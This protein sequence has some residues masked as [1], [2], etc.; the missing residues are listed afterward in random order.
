MLEKIKS[1]VCSYVKKWSGVFIA[2]L[3]LSV[4][5]YSLL[6]INQLVNQLDGLWHGSESVA[7]G[8][9]LSIGRWLWP[10]LDKARFHMSPDPVTSLIALV[11]F[12]TALIAVLEIF[13]VKPG[14]GAVAISMIFL[15]S[16]SVCN[17]LSFRYMSLTFTFAFFFAVVAAIILIKGKRPIITMIC[18]ALFVVF[19]NALYQA[20][21]G[22]ICLLIL[23]YIA[24]SIKKNT[25]D[26]RQLLQFT[27]RSLISGVAGV[28]VYYLMWMEKLARNNV[29]VS[30]YNGASEYGLSGVITNFPLR[31]AT[32]YHA[33][34]EYFGNR[35]FRINT[36]PAFKWMYFV[37]V[38]LI[39]A[40]A[41][42]AIVSVA[43][44]GIGRAVVYAICI[45]LVPFAAN[46]FL[47]IA[48]DSFVS[49]QMTAPMAFS[50]AALLAFDHGGEGGAIAWKVVGCLTWC[51]V[52]V[53]LYTQFYMVQYD[54]Q[55][56]YMGRQ[57][58]LTMADQIDAYLVKHDLLHPYYKY[59][60]VGTP[61]SNKEFYL[62]DFFGTANDYAQFGNF[63]PDPGGARM[64]WQGLWWY[65]RGI[66]MDF[67]PV[68]KW[69]AMFE[70]AAVKSMPVFP[71]EGSCVLY[72]DVIVIKVSE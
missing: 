21:T 15:I 9:E 51:V 71:E 7:A 40:C 3:V 32:T 59:V 2:D 27:I 37:L 46:V 5:T 67:A 17:Q 44:Q 42:S 70:D 10:Y 66:R 56:M 20:Y 22:V 49:I 63:T 34:F 16:V 13:D 39:A 26:N 4:I 18:G 6:M 68:D 1:S 62:N 45:L 11:L 19:T 61:S 53:L 30:N 12:I 28:I 69:E 25:M 47:V 38:L 23:L 50:I 33:F 57:S 8:H 43:K 58:C 29:E 48:Y 31:F 72:N 41:F 24:Y 14:I 64:S 52:A 54:E 35:V 36:V 65:E 55:S 60:F